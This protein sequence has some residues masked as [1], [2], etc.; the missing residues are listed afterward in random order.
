[1]ECFMVRMTATAAL[2][3]LLVS[4]LPAAA[5]EIV[6]P[7]FDRFNFKLEGSAV[8]MATTIRLD[9][10]TLGQGTTLNF[11]DDLGLD[12][13][14]L[15][16]TLSFEWQISRKH[17]LAARWQDLPRGSN[18]QILEEIEWGDEI[19]PIESDV[20]LDFQVEQ[21]FF[22]LHLLP[23]GQ[24]KVGGAALASAFAG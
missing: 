3:V 1:M 13:Q 6:H 2:V 14:K 17:R 18:T 8:G 21:I 7:L 24:G 16:P 22:D 20:S 9:S 5:Q 23:L 12:N 15:I 4:T 11:E 19:I 10:T